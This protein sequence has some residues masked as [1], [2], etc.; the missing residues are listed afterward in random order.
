MPYALVTFISLAG[1]LCLVWLATQPP[2]EG[3][4]I[5][6]VVLGFGLYQFLSGAPLLGMRDGGV[7][8]AVVGAAIFVW[9]RGWGKA[10]AE[11]KERERKIE[12][13]KPK[14]SPFCEAGECVSICDLYPPNVRRAERNAAEREALIAAQRERDRAEIAAEAEARHI[15]AERFRAEQEAKGYTVFP[16]RSGG[17]RSS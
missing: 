13:A 17:T 15:W 8:A 11:R 1:W 12:A 9:W 7:A 10:D 2:Y 6:W 4:T 14:H 5:G 16:P 3:G